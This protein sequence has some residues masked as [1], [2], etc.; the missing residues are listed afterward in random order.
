MEIPLHILI[1][2]IFGLIIL[3]AFFSGSETSLTSASKP[4]M[5]NLARTGKK[6]A[7]IFEEL[8][9]NKEMLICTILFAN[10]LVNILASAIATKILIELT[11]NE[12][13]LYATIIMTLMILIFGELIPKTLALSKAD[14]FALKIA[15]FMKVLVYIL[16]PLT[17]TLNFVATSILK[18]FGVNY[19]NF[20]KEEVSEKREEELRG[21]IDLHGDDSSKDEKNML[22]SILDL[23]DIT[24]GSIMIPRKDIFSLPS[25]IKYN[26]LITKLNNSPHSRI[27][28]WEKNPENII[29]IFHIRKLIEIKVD[30]P[31]TFNIKSLCQKPWFIPESTRLDN[32][33]LEFKR[34]KEH[35]SIVVD[36]YGEFLGIVTLEDIIEEIVGE[37]DDEHDV[38][39]ISKGS[40][41]IKSISSKSYLVKG[42]VT[43]RELNKELNINIPVSN[44]STVAGLVLYESRTIPK[45]GQIFSFFDLKFEI[46][47]KKN[48][49]ITLV[50]IIK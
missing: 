24:V 33:L 39:K 37:I 16:Y 45:K 13:I 18:I 14:Q 47:S 15:P 23:D 11:N 20:K 42:N 8:F 49:Q 2:S 22:K 50:K 28:I 40:E 27:P 26:E 46:L 32:Q 12:G 43:I 10:N 35:F 30:E 34:R 41:D 19:L 21:A 9:K 6:N 5:H 48:N 29:G 3:S 1:G 7:K 36:E 4:R 44:T 31:K 25:N 38:L 17:V